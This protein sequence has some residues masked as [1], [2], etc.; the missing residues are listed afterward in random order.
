VFAIEWHEDA[1]AAS[2]LARPA[3]CGEGELIGRAFGAGRV[4]LLTAR[5]GQLDLVRLG[6]DHGAGWQPEQPAVLG[7]QSGWAD[8]GTK[9]A[10][11]ADWACSAYEKGSRSDVARVRWSAVGLVVVL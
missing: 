4:Q 1:R 9:V 8:V 11:I 10:G 6:L 5:R 7:K 2:M 3:A